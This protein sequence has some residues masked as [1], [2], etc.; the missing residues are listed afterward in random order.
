MQELWLE[1]TAL[2]PRDVHK[3]LSAPIKFEPSVRMNGGVYIN[4]TR[5]V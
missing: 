2:I 4:A 5:L 3:Q 1:P